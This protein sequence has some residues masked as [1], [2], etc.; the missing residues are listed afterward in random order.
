MELTFV[1][2]F[3]LNETGRADAPQDSKEALLYEKGVNLYGQA[4][5]IRG[6]VQ[7]LFSAFYPKFLQLGASPGQLM[8]LG[9]IFFALV[10]MI[11]ADTH[12]AL[13]AQL[14]VIL[15]SLPNA[16]LLTLPIGLTVSMSDESNRGRYLGALNVF[17][18]VPQLIDTS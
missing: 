11:F 4:G 5:I 6:I 1:F 16:C 12:N 14:S 3:V 10:T 8:C 17:A 13:I 7:I 9:F 15:Y 2:F 18:V